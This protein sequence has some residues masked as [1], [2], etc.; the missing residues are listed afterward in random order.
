VGIAEAKKYIHEL[1][2]KQDNPYLWPDYLTGLPDKAAIIKRL[3]DV[4][5][6]LGK[7]SIAYV[8]I[9]NVHPY[10]I[11]YGP[12][13]HAEVIQWAAAILKTTCEKCENCFVGT[14]STHDFVIMCE[15]ENLVKHVKEAGRIFKAQTR[16]YYSREDCISNSV[17][18]F[19]RNGKRVNIGLMRLV[20]VIAD[21]KLPVE[22]KNLLQKM[23]KACEAAETGGKDIIILADN[24]VR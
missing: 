13:R 22:K 10:L 15:T 18:S 9:A 12:D 19:S 20:T 14:L 11:K 17:M 3:E 5:S 8:R 24:M 7:F 16:K 23:G 4:F 6:R 1:H 2:K 21:K